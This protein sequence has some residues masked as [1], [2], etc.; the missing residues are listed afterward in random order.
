MDYCEKTLDKLVARPYDITKLRKGGSSDEPE[1]A[2][3]KP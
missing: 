3:E 2:K 1:K